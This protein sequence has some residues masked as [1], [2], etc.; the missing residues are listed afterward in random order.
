V[1]GEAYYREYDKTSSATGGKGSVLP[2]YLARRLEGVEKIVGCGALLEI[3][4]GEGLFLNHARG[5][6]WEVHGVEISD[7][8]VSAVKKRFNLPN[9]HAGDLREAH[10][11]DSLFDF[12]HLNHV[13]EHLP[14]P[15]A[16]LREIKR[17]AKPD[18]L[19][20]IEVPYEFDNLFDRVREI[21]G[22]GQEPYPIPSAHF[23]FFTPATLARLMKK[24]GFEIG[25]LRT[26]RRNRE[27]VSRYAGGALLKGIVYR[28]EDL[29][30]RGPLIELWASKHGAT[31]LA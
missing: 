26:V 28:M 2:D 24:E 17:I 16:T 14:D 4:F 20:V 23:W 21:L 30:R 27:R 19:V 1:Y 13:F 11:G 29:L 7:W 12:I 15:P 31:R 3:G 10:F 9:L 6:G 25:Q 18:C 8:A 5:R 22:K